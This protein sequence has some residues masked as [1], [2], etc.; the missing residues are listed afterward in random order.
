MKLH[1]M[2][3]GISVVP[4]SLFTS[5]VDRGLEL[6]AEDSASSGWLN[7]LK[8]SSGIVETGSQAVSSRSSSD[9]ITS[10]SA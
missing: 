1:T 2:P 4:L 8:S 3:T 5:T 9:G 7:T 6:V 10:S